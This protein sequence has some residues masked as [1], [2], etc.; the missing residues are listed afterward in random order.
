MVM[1]KQQALHFNS[2]AAGATLQ[3]RRSRRYTIMQKLQALNYNAKEA[4]AKI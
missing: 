2:E 1:Q 3:S 4:F